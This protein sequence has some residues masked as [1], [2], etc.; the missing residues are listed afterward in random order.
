MLE[1]KLAE[2]LEIR[3]REE[4]E[5]R[6]KFVAKEEENKRNILMDEKMKIIQQQFEEWMRLVGPSKKPKK[7]KDGKKK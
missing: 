6:N 1:A 3:R 5:I 2:E 7:D 4:G